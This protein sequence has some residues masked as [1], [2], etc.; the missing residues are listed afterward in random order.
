MCRHVN[1]L[2][3]ELELTKKNDNTDKEFK[4]AQLQEQGEADLHNLSDAQM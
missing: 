3:T 1:E 4:A 2:T